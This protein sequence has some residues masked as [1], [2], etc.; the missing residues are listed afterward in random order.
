M[1]LDIRTIEYYTAI[2]RT[3]A[4]GRRGCLVCSARKNRL[5]AAERQWG[6]LSLLSEATRASGRFHPPMI[7]SRANERCR[8]GANEGGVPRVSM[9]PQKCRKRTALTR[10]CISS[11]C[12]DA[13][14][15]LL[16][17]TC[18]LLCCWRGAVVKKVMI[19]I[20]PD[21]LHLDNRR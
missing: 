21:L 16:L 1:A 7:L 20:V 8:G 12:R 17:D 11:A 6:A 9:T 14:R 10:A 3:S 19:T 18:R 13:R 5:A 2:P 15:N 4:T